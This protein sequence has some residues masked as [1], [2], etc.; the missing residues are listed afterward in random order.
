MVLATP[1]GRGE[2][3][4]SARL[5]FTPARPGLLLTAA[6]KNRIPVG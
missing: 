3:G 1:R 2:A 4:A 5:L 6:S